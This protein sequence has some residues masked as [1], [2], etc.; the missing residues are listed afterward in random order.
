MNGWRTCNTVLLALSFVQE[1]YIARHLSLLSLPPQDWTSWDQPSLHCKW[2][3]FKN[4]NVHAEWFPL[5]LHTDIQ[6]YYLHSSL[7]N[8]SI[9]M[10]YSTL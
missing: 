6:K 8:K 2:W 7:A 3:K 4:Q 9:D 10:H 1:A 5:F